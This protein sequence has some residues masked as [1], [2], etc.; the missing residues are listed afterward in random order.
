[1]P[2]LTEHAPKSEALESLINLI[3]LYCK[4]ILYPDM[5]VYL[6]VQLIFLDQQHKTLTM[7]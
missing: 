2:D 1:M 5:Y 7:H 4:I 6:M 3:M